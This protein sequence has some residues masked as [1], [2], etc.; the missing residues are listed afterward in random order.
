MSDSPLTDSNDTSPSSAELKASPGF[1]WHYAWVIVAIAAIMQMVGSSIRMAFGVFIDPL[2]ETFMWDQGDITLA[3]GINS[4]VSAIASPAAGWIGDRFGTRKAMALG[5]A[6]FI[7]GMVITGVIQE[8][9]QLYVAFGV[10]LGI[11]QAI[12]LVPLLPGAMRWYRRQLGWGMGILMASWGIGPALSAPLMGYM[13]VHLDWQ[14]TFWATA[15]GSAVI[16]AILIYLYRDD[17]SDIGAEPYGALPGETFKVEIVIDKVRARTWA[18]HMKKTSAYYNM[19]SIHFLGCVGHAV[20]LV[21]LIPIAVQEGI[22]L[23]AAATILAVMAAISVPSRFAVP[24]LSEK[25]GVRTVMAVFY[26]LQGVTVIMLF[27][28]H[29]HWMFYLF[30]LVFGIAYGGESGGFPILNRRYYGHAPQG[31]PYGFQMLGAGLGMAL[32]GWI[33][34]IVFD[35]TSGYG[36]ALVISIVASLAGMVSIMLLEPADELLIPDWEAEPTPAGQANP[37]EH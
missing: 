10:F 26:F 13:I 18:R 7:A 22:D 29:E 33:G 25:I 15:G 14:G 31:S 27:W 34:G 17:P 36:W 30:A 19:S 5:A 28:T 3:Y 35:I 11:A 37:G 24:V 9:W 2:S 8:L 6:M 12:F 23:V 20:I 32:G 16:M 21:Y 1:Y 4:V